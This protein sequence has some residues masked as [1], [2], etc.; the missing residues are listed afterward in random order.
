MIKVKVKVGCLGALRYFVETGKFPLHQ[1][2]QA[3]SYTKMYHER[4]TLDRRIRAHLR[5][6]LNNKVR[7]ATMPHL[8]AIP[9]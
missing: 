8:P 1:K 6:Y 4:R 2:E 3:V 7:R 9:E 5:A